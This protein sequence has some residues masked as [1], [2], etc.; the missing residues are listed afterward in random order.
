MSKPT[1]SIEEFDF[2][3]IRDYFINK[4]KEEFA[5]YILAIDT[6]RGVLELDNE[7]NWEWNN[8]TH[9]AVSQ[10]LYF[11]IMRA[12]Y[13]ISRGYSRKEFDSRIKS[14]DIKADCTTIKSRILFQAHKDYETWR[15][16]PI[17]TSESE[18]SESS[19][20]SSPPN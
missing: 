7:G 20:K 14:K 8:S 6:F 5:Q 15:H 19:A 16:Q 13:T 1:V 11:P 9:R 3:L 17:Q 10:E 4:G 18:K 12:F 2:K